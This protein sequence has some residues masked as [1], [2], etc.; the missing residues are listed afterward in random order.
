[1]TKNTRTQF[2]IFE[3]SLEA[4]PFF[5]RWKEYKRSPKSDRHVTIQQGKHKK[6]FRYI[7]QHRFEEDG[8]KFVFARG[9]NNT[10]APQKSIKLTLAG[11]YTLLQSENVNGTNPKDSKV[12]AFIT[13]P[14]AD[15]Q[16]Y[17]ELAEGGKLNIYEPYYHNC[18]FEYILEYFVKSDTADVLVK[19]LESLDTVDAAVYEEFK[20][21]K[22]ANQPVK[23]EEFHVW[24]SF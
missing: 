4:E 21:V 7:A 16:I 15:L 13:D 11:G 24:P 19:Q 18:R 10:G 3:T 2:V 12:I 20:T 1:M 6:S 17:R 9:R 5:E 8:L 23:E 22:N 14:Q